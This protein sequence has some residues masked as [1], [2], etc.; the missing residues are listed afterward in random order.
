METVVKGSLL[1]VE[2]TGEMVRLWV[3]SPTGD[4]SDCHVFE[5]P[6]VNVAQAE[7]VATYWRKLK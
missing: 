1:V 4:S 2:Q 6:C 7:E 3:A 5:I